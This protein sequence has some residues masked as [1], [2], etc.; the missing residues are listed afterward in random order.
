MV[1]I[2]STKTILMVILIIVVAV[3]S[4]L[5]IGALFLFN[6][7]D[8][9]N[10]IK[11]GNVALIKIN[12]PI[13]VEDGVSFIA[14]DAIAST[15]IIEYIEKAKNDPSVRGII[16]EINSPG[17]S[18]V[19]S[20]EIGEAIKELRDETNK[21]TVAWIREVGASGG[22]WVASAT[23]HI[24]ANKMSITGSIGVIASYLEFSGLLEKYDVKYQRMVSGEHKDMGSPLK[25]MT[26]EEE[27]LF[28]EQLDL[29]HNYFIE[30]VA[31][32]RNLN[33][34][35]IQKVSDGSIILGAKAKELGLVDELGSKKEALEYIE[36]KLSIEAELIEYKEAPSFLELFSKIMNEHGFSIGRGIGSVFSVDND[37]IIT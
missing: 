23:E 10:A 24:V 20:E 26:E 1:T 27:A 4:L 37:K 34:E 33:K 7:I 6:N 15:K 30:E 3:I 14:S 11:K 25:E 5:V 17:G 32:N 13:M 31:K 19:A 36:K 29:I 22:Y 12:G 9:G 16:F 28:Q 2:K 35:Q 21:I 8:T 18:A